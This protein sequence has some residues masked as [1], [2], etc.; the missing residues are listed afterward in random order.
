MPLKAKCKHK[1]CPWKARAEGSV[2]LNLAMQ[3]HRDNTG[4]TVKMKEK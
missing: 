2:Y 1:G 4:H 3:A